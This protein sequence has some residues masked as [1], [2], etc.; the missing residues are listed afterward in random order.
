MHEIRRFRRKRHFPSHRP[1]EFLQGR[2]QILPEAD[3][4]PLQLRMAT[5][6][7]RLRENHPPRP[8]GIRQGNRR[9][10]TELYRPDGTARLPLRT[11]ARHP[12]HRPTRRKMLRR[13]SSGSP[14]LQ[15]PGTRQGPSSNGYELPTSPLPS[16]PRLR[17]GRP[18]HLL[19]LPVSLRQHRTPRPV[20]PPALPRRTRGRHL[21]A[22]TGQ[23]ALARALHHDPWLD[24]DD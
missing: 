7:P 3:L 18:V 9:S 6:Q 23:G 21:D 11:G 8:R 22:R 14:R 20:S 5:F 12:R 10:E 13:L 19:L 4:Q 15:G 24:T 1:S 17:G 16:R 2:R